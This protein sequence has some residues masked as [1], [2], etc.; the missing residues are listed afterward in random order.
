AAGP[1]R[2]RGRLRAEDAGL[3]R[4]RQGGQR[5][6]RAGGHPAPEGHRQGDDD[7]RQPAARRG[8]EGDRPA[9]R[10][11]RARPAVPRAPARG[12]VALLVPAARGTWNAEARLL[13]DLQ[14]TC[15]DNEREI[16]AVDLVEWFV[17]WFQRPIKRLLPDQPLVL[18]V[19]NLRAAL[20][21]LPKARM[22]DAD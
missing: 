10:P 16:F 8:A 1:P 6:P 14:K 9:R 22:P 7:D 21:K 4:R 20:A 2:A 3:A 19:K 15:V 18:T 5:Q 13:Y 12:L 11:P 17:T